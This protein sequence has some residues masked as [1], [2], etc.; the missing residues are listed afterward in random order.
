LFKS[1]D[2][3][4]EDD[5]FSGEEGD[6]VDVSGVDASIVAGAPICLMARKMRQVLPMKTFFLTA[7]KKLITLQPSKRP[8]RTWQMALRQAAPLSQR[9]ALARWHQPLL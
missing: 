5:S 1:K 7:T 8:K 2:D 4:A 3:A 9:P 6:I